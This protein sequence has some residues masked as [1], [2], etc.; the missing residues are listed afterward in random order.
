M[1]LSPEGTGLRQ[2]LWLPFSKLQFLLFHASP[3]QPL[4]KQK[5][6]GGLEGEPGQPLCSFL[7]SPPTCRDLGEGLGVLRGAREAPLAFPPAEMGTSLVEPRCPL[8]IR[9]EGRSGE[10]GDP[11][12]LRGGRA[13]GTRSEAGQQKPRV[14]WRGNRGT[15]ALRSETHWSP[16]AG[17]GIRWRLHSWPPCLQLGTPKLVSGFLSSLSTVSCQEKIKWPECDLPTNK[18][19]IKFPFCLEQLRP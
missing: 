9:N 10:R 8:K 4:L 15:R 13:G 5:E 7:P 2:V 19:G 18:T 17:L 6:Q 3:V 14:G 11:D 16:D 12:C 1:D